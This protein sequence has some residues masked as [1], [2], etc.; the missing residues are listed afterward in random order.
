M[1]ISTTALKVHL[2]IPFED[3]I[4]QVTDALKM[5]GFGVLTSIDM[6]ATFKNKLHV[7][8]RP[9]TILGACNPLL[10]HQAVTT[11]PE[12]GLL[13]PCN[14][15]VVQVDD[16]TVEISFVDPVVMLGVVDAPGLHEVAGDV[17]AKFEAVIDYL[18][19]E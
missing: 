15:T 14:V 8:F 7:D 4:T 17:R 6:R 16:A 11:A 10:A 3:A 19:A 13:L 18:N 5:Q 2:N 9:Y 12:V 1:S